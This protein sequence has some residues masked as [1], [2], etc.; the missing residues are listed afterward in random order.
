[1]IT[2]DK[3]IRDL[4]HDIATEVCKLA[5]EGKLTEEE[6]EKIVYQVSPGPKPEYRCC[7]YK[8]REIVPWAKIPLG[9]GGV[10]INNP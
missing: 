4:K 1:M 2:N 6:R 7:I 8:E 10:I 9:L 3:G 5:W